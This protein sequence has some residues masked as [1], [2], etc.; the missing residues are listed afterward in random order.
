MD[1]R[2][3]LERSGADVRPTFQ[4]P[5]S[6]DPTVKDISHLRPGQLLPGVITNVTDSGHLL[7]WVSTT[8][9]YFMCLSSREVGSPPRAGQQFQ[10]VVLH[11]DVT[12]KRIGLKI[13]A[14]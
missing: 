5:P 8:M 1:I 10:F 7:M 6:F 14:L 9:A 13:A 3:E 11:A 4:A 2:K 12:R